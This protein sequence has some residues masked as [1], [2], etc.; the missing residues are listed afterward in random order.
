[1]SAYVAQRLT[2]LATVFDRTLSVRAIL[3]RE[4]DHHRVELVSSVGRGQVLVVNARGATVGAALGRAM[5]R[6]RTVLVKHKAKRY[7]RRR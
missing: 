5:A 7:A 3:D 1:M 2:E 4:R 6:M